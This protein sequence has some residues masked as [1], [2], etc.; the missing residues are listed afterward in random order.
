MTREQ[1]DAL[2]KLAKKATPY[3]YG[4]DGKLRAI[5]GYLTTRPDISRNIEHLGEMGQKRCGAPFQAIP[6]SNEQ[7]AEVI[8]AAWNAL[9]ELIAAARRALELEEAL[10]WAI[11]NSTALYKMGRGL[12][13]CSYS[14][15]SFVGAT[16]L[17]AIQKAQRGEPQ[18]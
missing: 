12:F 18:K 15:R 5:G 4:N 11:G 16:P 14:S 1:L 10:E 3:E 2:E 17:E 9:P 13:C 7:D 8:A 6:F